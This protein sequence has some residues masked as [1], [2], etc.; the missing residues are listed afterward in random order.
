MDNANLTVLVHQL[1]PIVAILITFGFPV[2]IVW[3]VK[4]F[5]LKD[6]ELE[7]EAQLHSRELEL[8]LRTLEA[9]QSAVETALTAIGAKPAPVEDRVSLLE[10]P[11]VSSSE[12]TEA[13]PND[14]Q[15]LRTR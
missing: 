2:A 7:L 8:R 5:K 10:A 12:T 15:R 6:R 9:R 1:V 11:A 4:H 3:T 14:P 13:K